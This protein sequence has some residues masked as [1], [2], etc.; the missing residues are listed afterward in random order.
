MCLIVLYKYDRYQRGGYHGIPGAD[1]SSE[2]E[3]SE[4]LIQQEERV[5]NPSEGDDE[6]GEGKRQGTFL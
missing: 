3:E 4:K 2:S 6:E 5:N 1:V